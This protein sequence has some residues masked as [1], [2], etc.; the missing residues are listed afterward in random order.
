[1]SSL[2]IA[3]QA[4]PSLTKP[5]LAI[6]TGT[7]F[8]FVSIVALLERQA[9]PSIAADHTLTGAAFGV[10]LPLLG[11]ALLERLCGGTSLEASLVPFVR[12]GANRRNAAVTLVALM[13]LALGVCGAVLGSLAVVLSRGLSDPGLMQDLFATA[14]VGLQAGVAYASWFGLG[15]T[16][17]RRGQ[18]RIYL[19]VVDWIFGSGSAILALPWPRGHIRNLLGAEPVLG[20]SQAESSIFLLA[21]SAL[22]LGLVGL[23]T[24]R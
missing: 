6:V 9:V 15:S 14:G 11:L 10:A 4:L 17:G 23:K 2:R 3:L 12:F 21:I 7:A 24:A 22:A 13:M 5:R 16:L 8:L 20:F 18:G 19:L 1:M